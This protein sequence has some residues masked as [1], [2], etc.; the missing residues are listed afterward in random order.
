MRKRV[1]F[2]FGYFG[3]GSDQFA[4]DFLVGL[5]ID[6][7]TVVV[8]LLNRIEQICFGQRFQIGLQVLARHARIESIR[9]GRRKNVLT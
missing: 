3:S 5:R 2:A 9:G 1:W 8:Q 7:R 4:K 6:R